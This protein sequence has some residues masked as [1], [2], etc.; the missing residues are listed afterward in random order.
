MES[1]EFA[2][3]GRL[4]E[5]RFFSRLYDL[6]ALPS[7]DHRFSSAAKDLY[8]HL[9][10]NDDWDWDWFYYFYNDN[11]DMIANDERFLNFLCETLHPTV[12]AKDSLWRDYLEKYNNLLVHDGFKIVPGKSIS[13][14]AIYVYT[15]VETNN[16][17]DEYTHKIKE[18]FDSEYINQQVNFMMSMINENP[19]FAIGKSKEL[20]ESCAKTILDEWTVQYD[21]KIEFMPLMRK[22]YE[23][24]GL[25]TKSQDKQSESSKIAIK[26]LG[27][28]VTIT[29]SMAELRN[30]YG[31]GHG[32]SR[33]FRSLPPRYA[34]LSVG[35]AT[36]LVHFL[37]ETH[38]ERSV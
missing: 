5:V 26:I 12:V 33:N 30:A 10:N 25:D 13:G 9:V 31:D 20:L 6:D 3:W 36:T 22:T 4:D 16:F 34:R 7:T 28:L 18:K 29:Q 19:N 2:Y 8:Q 17:L 1:Q 14:R 38:E 21:S 15:E 24:L 27:S 23:A 35:T 37:W 11:F 32:K